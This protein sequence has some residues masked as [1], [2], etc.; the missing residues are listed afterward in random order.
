VDRIV[1]RLGEAGRFG[2][3]TL[4]ASEALALART[5]ADGRTSYLE[6]QLARYQAGQTLSPI[7]H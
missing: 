4:T 1:P 3:A 7:P 2:E 5:L 6:Q